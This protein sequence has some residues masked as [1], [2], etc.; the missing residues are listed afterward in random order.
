VTTRTAWGPGQRLLTAGLVFLVTATAFEGLAVPTVL[1]DTLEQLGGLDLYGWAFS[2]YWLANLVGIT[3]AGIEADR[4]GPVRPFMVGAALAGLGLAVAALG[5]VMAWVVAGRVIQGLGAG[6]IG[7]IVYVAIARG[8]D[9]SARPRMIAVISSAWVIP[10]L[11]GPALAGL[12]AEQLGWRW[13]FGGLAPL[14]PAAAVAVAAPLGRLRATPA[15]SETTPPA[16]ASD[17][18]LLAAG[19]GLVLAAVSLR[20]VLLGLLAAVVGILGVRRALVRLL[21]AGT[22]RARPGRA[23]GIAALALVSIAFFGAEAFVPLAVASVRGAGT[24]AGG[25]ALTTAAVTWAAGSWIQARLAVGGTRRTLV[26][27][28]FVLVLGGIALETSVPLTALAP[29]W[30]APLAWAIAGLG[31]GLTYSTVTLVALE[32]APAGAEGAT[33]AAVQLANTLGIAIGTGVAGAIVAYA[34]VSGP[35]LAP[36][37]ALA[38]LLMLAVCLIG[39]FVVRRLPEPGRPTHVSGPVPSEHGPTL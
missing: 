14:I 16:R 35:G 20:P 37:I 32:T 33:S 8:Y 34:A 23:A 7:A 30:V 31:M 17:A 27:A 12:V 6:A 2:G 4:R 3:L 26:A 24:L 9:G 11:V 21:P 1:P 22:L 25:L 36:G 15:G 39:L 5:D 19:S 29:I 10:G 28:G 13:V 38:N 18:I